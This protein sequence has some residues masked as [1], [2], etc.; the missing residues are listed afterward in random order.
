MGDILI[1]VGVLLILC[2][3]ALLT[4]IVWAGLLGG[5][6]LVWMGVVE[7]RDEDRRRSS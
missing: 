7:V 5:L 1:F 4:S 3:V 6:I 2:M